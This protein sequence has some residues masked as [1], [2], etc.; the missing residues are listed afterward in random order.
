MQQRGH[1]HTK[2]DPG[3]TFPKYRRFNSFA[4]SEDAFRAAAEDAAAAMA[5]AFWYASSA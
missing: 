5:S 4:K 2:L 3:E 1:K